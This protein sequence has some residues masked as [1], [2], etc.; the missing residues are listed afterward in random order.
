LHRAL[1]SAGLSSLG[2]SFCGNIRVIKSRKRRP[3]RGDVVA[4]EACLAAGIPS[5][6][7]RRPAEAP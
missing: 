7:Q 6:S 5:R 1:S 2:K 3:P 4:P